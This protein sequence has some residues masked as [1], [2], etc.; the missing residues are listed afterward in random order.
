MGCFKKIVKDPS[1][2]RKTASGAAQEEGSGYKARKTKPAG[3]RTHE[4]EAAKNL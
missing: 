1:E 2:I 4:E 3:T